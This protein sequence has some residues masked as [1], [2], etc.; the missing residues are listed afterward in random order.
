[1]IAHM[2]PR[3][4]I[5]AE[6]VMLATEDGGRKSLAGEGYVPHV[7][8]QDRAIRHATVDDRGQGNEEYLGVRLIV[9]D[10]LSVAGVSS[11]HKFELMYWPQVDYSKVVPGASFTIREGARI[12]GHG[13]VLS[14]ENPVP[15]P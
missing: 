11:E 10:G 13:V 6:V 9:C 15:A 12:V 1:M 2:Q 5:V 4:T 7:V 3:P 14:R 8:I